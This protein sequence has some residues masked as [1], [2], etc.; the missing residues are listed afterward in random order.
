[1]NLTRY[2][3]VTASSGA[4][5]A[6]YAVDGMVFE[7]SR[8][9]SANVSTPHWLEV[10]L[11]G[12]FE[13]GSANVITGDWDVG[14]SSFKLQSWT[15]SAWA[16]IPGATVTGNTKSQRQIVFSSPVTTDKVRFYSDQDWEIEVKELAVFPPNGGAG[17]PIDT[18]IDIRSAQLPMITASSQNSA[19]QRPFLAY[20]GFAHDNSRWISANVTT[21]HWLE[22]A[23]VHEREVAYAHVYT[24]LGTGSAIANFTLQSWEAASSSWVN[25][26]GG[27]VTGNTSTAL[28]LAFQATIRTTKVRLVSDDDGNIRV[29][30]LVFLP[31]NGGA[32]Y[33]L[34]TSVALEAPPSQRWADF[35]DH[36]YHIV[37]RTGGLRLRTA[38]DGTV[39]VEMTGASFSQQY[40]I[41]LNIGTDTY[42][43]CNRANERCLE[44]ANASL[45][46]GAAVREGDYNALPYQQ[47]RLVGAGSYTKLVNVHS[48][49]RLTVDGTG[50]VAGS[51]L[52]QQPDNADFAQQWSFI[53]VGR[54]PKKGLSSNEIRGEIL[55]KYNAS[56]YYNWSLDPYYKYEQVDSSHHQPMWWGI[57][58]DRL[59][60]NRTEMLLMMR[61]EWAVADVPK[62]L[63]G[64]N[65]PNHTDQSNISVQT[66]LNEWS[67]AEQVKLPLV[68]P[69]HDYAWGSWY[70]SFYDQADAKGFRI[71]EGG[72]HIYPTSSSVNYD[73]FNNGVT[74][75]Y[76]AQNNR[77]QWVTELNWVN[78]GGAATWTD[79]QLYSVLAETLWR[80]E[81]NPWVKRYQWFAFSPYWA[82]GAPGALEKDG[83]ILP[84]GRLYGA[85]DGDLAV[86]ENTWYHIHN[87]GYNSHLRNNGGSPDLATINTV[88]SSVN[89]HLAPAGGGKVY[90]VSKAG[91]RL[92]SDGTTVSLSPVG[93]TGTAV[94]WSLTPVAAA[95]AHYGWYYLHHPASGKR[96]DS[97]NGSTFSMTTDTDNSP[98]WRFIK[99]YSATP[100]QGLLAR[101]KFETTLAN[102]SDAG[103]DA[104]AT[105]SPAFTAGPVGQAVALD[106]TDD[107]ITASIGLTE[108]ADITVATWVYW[109]GGS[110]WQRIFDF[111]PDTNNYMFLTPKAGGGGGLR[112]TMKNGSGE[113]QLNAP[114]LPIGE[115]THVAVTLSG[116]RGTMYV[117]GS[118]VANGTI[119]IN[120]SDFKGANHYI[121]KSLYTADP[122]FSGAIDD[123]S[124]YNYA[125][126]A[127]EIANLVPAQLPPGLVAH[128]RFDDDVADSSSYHSDATAAGGPA[129][130][131][132]E[133]GKAINFDG[134][135]D[136]LSVPAN[137]TRSVDIT[138][139]AWVRWGG[140]GNWQRLFDFGS[141]TGEYMFLTPKSGFNTLRFAFTGSGATGEQ[142]LEAPALAI[143]KWTHVAVVLNGETGTLYVDGAAVDS[144]AI[145]LNPYEIGSGSS[146][147]GKAQ[148]PDPLLIG[149]VDDFRVYNYA[150]DGAAIVR[151][152]GGAAVYDNWVTGH[153]FPPGTNE[154]SLDAD[155]DGMA[156]VLEW[157]FGTEPVGSTSA[158]PAWPKVSLKSVSG[159]EFPGAD[160]S[161]RYLTLTATV[162]KSIP[163][164]TLVAQAADSPTSLNDPGSS[165]D[166]VSIQLNDL[167]DFEERAWIHTIPAGDATSCFMRIKLSSE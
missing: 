1:M 152:A 142:V 6:K 57:T 35:S 112:F 76:N 44:V 46:A 83:N 27:T 84:L 53:N 66:A 23:F 100:A 162:R 73:S 55:K 85:W 101:Y 69:Q 38:P 88:D 59:G 103:S 105:G 148:Y 164:W 126:S 93:T 12:T 20:D 37:N 86:R 167:G 48:G 107:V 51:R 129:Y 87:R 131:T 117:N 146:F 5:T 166:I 154:P 122:L 113:Q 54:F 102:S 121:G 155:K 156:N 109:N 10:A 60:R 123:F 128:Y 160:S 163:G 104:T 144:R 68:G 63:L 89:W 17:F 77:I 15:G 62:H 31:P 14:V 110:D 125:L 43:I 7:Q 137:I 78:W 61:P 58:N 99:P 97:S 47:W 82:N 32:G 39:T 64:F 111:G 74:D 80:Y 106:G 118:A 24:G 158:S 21:Q 52:V 96:L 79:D 9:K 159:S 81:N 49:L 134:V 120:P 25:I 147:I 114:A 161:E 16:D 141:G 70:T 3:A 29:K 138:I 34:G 133:I 119:T 149:A 2:M 71:D 127:A 151:L 36:F 40:H 72:G 4:G 153:A 26:P 56:H 50:A 91:Q 67:R 13:I 132:G 28:S 135:N 8:W 157:L 42:R 115:W 116:D 92:G 11:P 140:G 130:T 136:V 165:N 41:L 108:S 90:I 18:T 33:P 75:G 45:T 124:V 145:T 95:P 19:S 94:E 65:E 143:G 139:A 98:R 22:Y 30:E 150:L